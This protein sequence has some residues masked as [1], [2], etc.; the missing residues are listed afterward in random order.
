V[1]EIVENILSHCH[2]IEICWTRVIESDAGII[3][4]QEN[5]ALRVE[6]Q[7]GIGGDIPVFEQEAAG[8]RQPS[9]KH[10]R[11]KEKKKCQ[12]PLGCDFPGA[13]HET[14]PE[15]VNI[16]APSARDSDGFQLLFRTLDDVGGDK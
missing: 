15:H 4:R 8:H 12:L 13:H 5:A 2:D 11:R 6:D 16:S 1:Q 14:P 9:G 3:A 10:Q 7:Q